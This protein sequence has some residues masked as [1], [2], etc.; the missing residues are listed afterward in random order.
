MHQK[1]VI[2]YKS[3]GIYKFEKGTSPKVDILEMVESCDCASLKQ[4]NVM[5]ELHAG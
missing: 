1:N 2:R 4:T 5:R 3:S